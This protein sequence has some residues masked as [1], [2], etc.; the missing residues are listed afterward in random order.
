MTYSYFCTG[1]DEPINPKRAALGYRLC[2]TCGER[3]AREI[4]RCTVPL[5]KQGYSLVT[6]RSELKQLNPKRLGE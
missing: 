1:C 3:E 6:N 4:K 2:L 5:H